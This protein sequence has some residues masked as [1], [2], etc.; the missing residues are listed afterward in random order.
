MIDIITVVFREE[1]PVL[2]LQAESIN[3]NCRVMC[4]HKI[5][6]VINDDLDPTEIDTAWWGRYA[7]R[8]TIIPRTHWNISYSDNGWLTQQLLKILASAE[9]NST[10]SMVLDA[11]TIIIQ[12][13]ELDRIFNDDGQLTWGYCPVFPVF[14]PAQQIVSKLFGIDQTDIAGPSGIPFFFHNQTVR[15]MIREVE[16]RTKQLF[17]DWF[18]QQG[19]VTEFI[20]YSGYVQYR[21]G[22]LDKMYTNQFS[23]RYL[24][25]NVCH[26]EVDSF[27]RKFL[28]MQRPDTLTVSVHR[29]A[30]TQLSNL[31]KESYR[32][33]LWA[34]G[35]TSAGNLV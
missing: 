8:V 5:Y 15:E 35:I 34:S 1:L 6:V 19:M 33:L 11:K 32:K 28:E 24:P 25:C 23:Q 10:W 2:Q 3:L 9:S 21:D 7:D 13:V 14:A 31:Q 20:L 12:P 27:D 17:A 4:L 26:S 16:S 30:W 22:S 29:R 18:Q